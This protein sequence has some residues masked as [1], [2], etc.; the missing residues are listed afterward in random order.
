MEIHLFS[1]RA[2]SVLRNT[3]T[4]KNKAKQKLYFHL[5][6]KLL[7]KG[8]GFPYMATHRQK[9]L[10]SVERRKDKDLF[11]LVYLRQTETVHKTQLAQHL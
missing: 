2:L 10:R 11:G 7:H 8:F 5:H 3:D 9:M 4:Y 1:P 6:L